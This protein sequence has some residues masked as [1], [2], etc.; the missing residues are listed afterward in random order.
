MLSLLFRGG[1]CYAPTL[2]VKSKTAPKLCTLSGSVVTLWTPNQ[3]RNQER[4]SGGGVGFNK[5]S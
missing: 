1:V 5:F 3:W 2:F 4:F